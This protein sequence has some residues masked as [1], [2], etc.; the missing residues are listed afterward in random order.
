MS[1]MSE[2]TSSRMTFLAN[3]LATKF[4][5]TFVCSTGIKTDTVCQ[6][7]LWAFYYALIPQPYWL[8]TIWLGRQLGQKG[9]KHSK[10]SRRG[11]DEKV[12][13][14]DDVALAATTG[15]FSRYDRV[16]E[17]HVLVAEEIRFLQNA[18]G[19][20]LLQFLEHNGAFDWKVVEHRRREANDTIHMHYMVSC[21]EELRVAKITLRDMLG[22]RLGDPRP[23]CN[24]EKVAGLIYDKTL[25]WLDGQP[26]V[27]YRHNHYLPFR[28]LATDRLLLELDLFG[29]QPTLDRC[30]QLGQNVYLCFE[31]VSSPGLD[32]LCS[33]D[34][35]ITDGK[36]VLCQGDPNGP[37]WVVPDTASEEVH[38][39]II[40]PPEFDPVASFYYFWEETLTVHFMQQSATATLVAR[41]LSSPI[42]F[43]TQ[44]PQ[45]D[46]SSSCQ[47]ADFELL[48]LEQ[49]LLLLKQMESA[50]S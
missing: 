19:R 27:R 30:K 29:L 5:A 7:E 46:I 34:S 17:G 23:K 8:D 44:P 1:Q 4:L 38:M 18:E 11:K 15:G 49:N 43:N 33:V 6:R 40:F 26:L 13:D 36:I 21:L 37:P 45:P 47:T 12:V 50:A 3:D 22:A 14:D 2:T 24:L 35:S 48:Q 32:V 28:L 41:V 20:S 31:K 10:R 9:I 42:T 16:Y 39:Q 25:I